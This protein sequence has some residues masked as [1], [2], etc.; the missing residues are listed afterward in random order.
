MSQP[1]KDAIGFCKTIMRNGYDAYVINARLQK[2][3]LDEVRAD[4]E[5]DIATEMDFAELSKHFPNIQPASGDGIIAFLKEGETTFYFYQGDTA[6]SAHP[7][8]CVSRMTPRLLKELEKRGEIPLSAVCPWI[9]GV[10]D[11]FE[12]FADFSEGQVRIIGIP[13]EALKRDYLLAVRILRFAAN[14]NL[15]V[16][17]NTWMAVVRAS[18]RVLDYVSISDIMDEW[19][20]VEAENMWQFSKM[21]FDSQLMHGLLPEVAALSRVKQIKNPEEGEETVLDHTLEVMRRYPEELPYDWYGTVACL[22]HDVGK[23]YTAEFDDENWSFYQHHRVG[24]RVTRKI[25]TRLRFPQE[26]TDLICEL[27]RNHMRPHFML[28]D[29]GIRR[30]KA[31]DEYPRIIEMVRA[32]IKAR[33]GNYRELNHNLKMLERADMPEEA[34]EP[35]LNGNEI[36]RVTGLHPG[37][38]VGILREALVKAQIAGDVTSQDEARRFALAY[39]EREQLQ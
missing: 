32:D 27:V 20:K 29:R 25:L 2:E 19:R 6:S 26:D 37:P 7:E 23:L 3:T 12:G 13:D 5:L 1:F 31:L 17:A 14:F 24:A 18:R 35:M 21:L 22:F 33:N 36:M 11:A 10:E 38:A 15:P 39:T 4:M 28:T 16:E 34:M 30:F 9:P 8:E